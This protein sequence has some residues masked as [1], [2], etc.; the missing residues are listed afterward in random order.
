MKKLHPPLPHYLLIPPAPRASRIF[1]RVHLGLAR[2]VSAL[3][4]FQWLMKKAADQCLS[5]LKTHCIRPSRLAARSSPLDWYSGVPSVLRYSSA[6]FVV[7]LDSHNASHDPMAGICKK[8]DPLA[9]QLTGFCIPGNFHKGRSHRLE[10][11]RDISGELA[12]LTNISPFFS[13]N[14]CKPVRS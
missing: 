2:V 7:T 14:D 1:D 11:I 10:E 5:C 13:Y 9:S 12:Y 8:K 6:P 3:D 4:V